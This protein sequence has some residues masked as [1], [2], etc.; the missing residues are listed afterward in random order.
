MKIFKKYSFSQVFSII[1]SV[2]PC[3]FCARILHF[4][5]KNTIFGSLIVGCVW[6]CIFDRPNPPKSRPKASKS[7]PR[8]PKWEP[9]WPFCP[10]KLA[11]LGFLEFL[12]SNGQKKRPGNLPTRFW[13]P[14]ASM[15]EGLDKSR[16]NFL[17]V[18]SLFLV[19][20]MQ[21]DR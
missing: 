15:L 16:T 2:P 7:S 12:Q 13:T 1:S 14:P 3:S 6:D 11:K 18:Q 4:L 21:Y 9:R 20:L 5:F 10:Q 8:A 17:T 19:C